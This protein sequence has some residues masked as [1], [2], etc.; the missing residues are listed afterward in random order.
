MRIRPLALAAL[1]A[2][3]SNPAAAQSDRLKL[4]EHVK[5]V[6][7]SGDL[8]LRYDAH[9]KSGPGLNDRNRGRFRLRPAVDID[10]PH[11]LRVELR[12]ASGSGD[13]NSTTQS[14]DNLGSGKSFWIDLTD[15]RWSPQLREDLT[16]SL[17][18]G[19]MLN[20]LWRTASSELIWDDELNPEGLGES[21]EWRLGGGSVFV[22]ALQAV[23]D[24]D[25]STGKNQWVF[26]EQLGAEVPVGPVKAR[27][28]AAYHFWSDVNRSS[29]SSP[30]AVD[31][32]RRT[33]ATAAG[34]LVNRFGVGELTAQVSGKAVGLPWSLQA[35]VARNL[36]ARDLTGTA[37]CAAAQTCPR[38]RDGYMFGG[39]LGT[40]KQ[41]GSWEAAVF[42]KHSQTDVTV[43]DA[44]DSDF[45]DGGTNLEGEICW[46][47]YAPLDWMQLKAKFFRVDVI[48]TQFSPGDK[49]VR[50]LQLDLSVKF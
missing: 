29:L 23:G 13:Q 43:A 16:L 35:T 37:T 7:L 27:A 25:S 39:V 34:V 15:L 49:A 50:R 8:R 3:A 6:K 31:G 28:A 33:A 38:A 21:A 12:F 36:L 1:V 11:D 14:F 47:A 18:A 4:A 19:K 32:N 24:D 10:L 44:A 46:L 5:S 41:A 17:A 20:P 40:A 2:L 48:D 9:R 45:G 30:A 22:N 26:S 42:R